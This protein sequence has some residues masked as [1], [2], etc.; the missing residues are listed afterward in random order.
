MPGYYDPQDLERLSEVGAERPDLAS[1][2]FA[3]YG[4]V[5]EDGALSEHTKALVA[6]AVAH[7]LQCPYCIDAYTN[8]CLARGADL[9]QMTEAIHVA[10]ALRGCA[11]LAHGMQTRRHALAAT[12]P[13]VP[14]DRPTMRSRRAPLADASAQLEALGRVP[15]RAEF[16]A[17]LREQGDWPLRP[18]RIETLQLNLGRR[19]N[20]T[21][22][23]CHVD[24]GP[25]R[26]EQMSRETM[27]Q[28][29]EALRGSDVPLV[30]LTG[31]APELHPDFRWLVESCRALGRR[32]MSRCNL[33]VLDLP[34]MEALPEFFAEMGVE[35][36]CSLPHARSASTDLQRGAGVFARS[37]EALR[38][39]N[40]LGYGDGRSGLRLV[41]V[42]NPVGAWLP[43]AQVGLETE[44]RVELA[45]TFGIRF[46]ELF[47]LA[48]MPI[49]RHLEFLVETGGLA[50]YLTGLA[51]AFNPAAARAAMCR[52]TVSVGWDGR[53]HDC[54]FNQMLE[55][56][57]DPR[58]PQHVRDFARGPLEAREIRVGR[59]CFG[60]TAGAGSSCGGATT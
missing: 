58:A 52:S 3:W 11:A 40:R 24:A 8:A 19:C 27:E 6:L 36:V 7:A 16:D 14:A 10:A 59:H 1:A 39:L 44:W 15:L 20:Q 46:D 5:F 38:R 51:D 41:L 30:D 33:T 45:R 42:A 53:L 4:A 26:T 31:G 2:F 21:C 60:C 9:E 57:L 47:C 43:G 50:R 25:E 23:H 49:A 54:D 28:C 32:V 55:M 12:G 37:I 56:G 22:R 17:R 18:T 48:N 34:G 35:L 29:L 13:R